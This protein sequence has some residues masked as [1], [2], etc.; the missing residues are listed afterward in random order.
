[1]ENLVRQQ[2]DNARQ[3]LDSAL[4][5]DPDNA[6]ALYMRVTVEQ[7]ELLDY[8]SYTIHGDTF[9]H[10]ADSILEVFDSRARG[11]DEVK[12]LFYKGN[13]CGGKSII[14][15]KTGNWMGAVKDALTS[16]SFLK[17]VKSKDP[18]FYAAYL[19]IGVF[20]YY[21]SQNLS[22]VP[23]LGDKSLEGLREIEKA[24]RA[25]FPFNYA[26]K[27][28]L[29][30]ILIDRKEFGKA[31]SVVAT[32]LRDYPDNTIFLR[33]KARIALWTG[34]YKKA[35]AAGKKLYS[36][37]E[38]RIPVNWSDFLSG[39]QIVAESCEKMGDYSSSYE[40]AATALNYSVPS[41]YKQ[42]GYVQ[43]HTDFLKRV[44]ENYKD[45]EKR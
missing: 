3:L 27:N 14:K 42:I 23:F 36:L 10:L 30:W 34:R 8:E 32:V 15:A 4:T 33:I 44:Q 41:P 26:A 13:I 11:K 29:A 20:N 2:Y 43:Q 25:K 16:V 24:T 28:T 31:D 6:D 21:L 1:M 19:G 18:D 45:R 39:Y 35:V 38:K 22:W 40:A 17:K 9:L 7:T 5:L 12:I 37:S